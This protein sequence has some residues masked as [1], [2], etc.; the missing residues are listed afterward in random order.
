MVKLLKNSLDGIKIN[1][2]LKYLERSKQIEI[3]LEGNI[4]WVKKP[5]E[6]ITFAEKAKIDKKFLDYMNSKKS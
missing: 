4:I 6:Q 3:D 1:T 2:I 5:K